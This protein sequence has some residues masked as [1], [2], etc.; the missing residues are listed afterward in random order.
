MTTKRVSDGEIFL[1][2]SSSLRLTRPSPRANSARRALETLLMFLCDRESE[3]GVCVWVVG[4][5]CVD[6]EKRQEGSLEER[7]DKKLGV[8]K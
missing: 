3:S 1:R 7:M 4:C 6:G 8:S 5:V 2:R